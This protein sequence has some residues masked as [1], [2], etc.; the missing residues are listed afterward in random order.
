[1]AQ[2]E[3]GGISTVIKDFESSGRLQVEYSRAP[4]SFALNRYSEIRPTVISDG[5]YLRINP[6]QAARL[7]YE[8]DRDHIWAPFADR[9][10]G[11]DNALQFEMA[12]FHTDRFAYPVPLDDRAV[13]MTVWNVLEAELRQ[14]AQQAMTAR[15]RRAFF[16]LRSAS[17]ATNSLPVDNGAG[18][19]T[20][21]LPAGQN[22]G[23]GT[24][25]RPNIQVSLQYA[26]NQ[27]LQATTGVIDTSDLVL[28]INPSDAMLM[29]Q[30]AE[31]RGM[32]SNSVYSYPQIT[33][34]MPGF[35]SGRQTNYG[36]PPMLYDVRVAVEKTVVVTS[37]KNAATTTRAYAVP[38]G[39]AY[40][41]CR[42]ENELVNPTFLKAEAEGRAIPAEEAKLVPVYSTLT[43][44]FKEEF[45]TDIIPQ[46]EHRRTSVSI[47]QDY[48][49]QVTS[50][51]SGFYFTQTFSV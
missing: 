20:A 47:V 36:L 9:P 51:L 25:A 35:P 5:F 17:W 12:S 24:V 10:T 34:Q 1:M 13:G 31:V 19:P 11:T 26:I 45:T 27:I 30:S 7:V 23:N 8:D 16:K 29:S 38:S 50:V 39:S 4:E 48:D 41:L 44:F 33:G 15:T 32:L 18:T 37:A 43:G 2:A 3:V 21:I 22:W 46:V 6:D 40:L 28:V 14:K 49:Y 42:R